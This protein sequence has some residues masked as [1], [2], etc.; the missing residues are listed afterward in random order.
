MRRFGRRASAWP[1]G[2]AEQ[3]DIDACSADAA[4]GSAQYSRAPQRSSWI[5]AVGILRPHRRSRWLV[6]GPGRCSTL[7]AEPSA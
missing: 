6:A 1:G 5:Q 4:P 2:Q 3:V 7:G